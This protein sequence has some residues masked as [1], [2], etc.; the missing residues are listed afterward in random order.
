[1]ELHNKKGQYRIEM[2]TRAVLE[3][4]P[5]HSLLKMHA[6]SLMDPNTQIVFVIGSHVTHSTPNFW[7]ILI[8][9]YCQQ[10]VEAVSKNVPPEE[11]DRHA[12]DIVSRYVLEFPDQSGI[13]PTEDL[14]RKNRI[15]HRFA[16]VRNYYINLINLNVPRGRELKKPSEIGEP[17]AL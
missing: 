14:G 3:D 5:A 13:D 15:R 6:D 9:D 10:A 4:E 8:K 12:D 1:M 11:R 2:D 7:D 17:H 16:G